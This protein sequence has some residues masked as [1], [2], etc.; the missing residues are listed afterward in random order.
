MLD[1]LNAMP[2]AVEPNSPIV[3]MVSGGSDSTALLVRSSLAPVDLK[4]GHG[5]RRLPRESLHVLH[6][7]HCLRGSESDGDEAFVRDLCNRLN[8]AFH[9]RRVDVA[10]LVREGAN[11]ED[12]ARQVRY[13]LAWELA[14]ELAWAKGLPVGAARILV[15]HTADDRAETFLMRALTGSGLTGL[16]GM[17]PRCGIVVRPLIGCTREELR[18]DLRACGIGWREDSTNAQDVATRSYVRHHVVPALSARN[19]SFVKTLGRSLDAMA[20]EEDLIARLSAELFERAVRPARAGF[21]VLDIETLAQGEP[22]LAPRCMRLALER[23]LGWQAARDAR[24]ESSHFDRLLDLVRCGAGS[25]SLPGGVQARVEQGM[26]VLRGPVVAR[27]P[28]DVVLPVPGAVKWGG[29]VLEAK[30]VALGRR[31]AEEAAH[32]L[33]LGLKER[34]LREGRDFVLVD[35]TVAGVCEPGDE[36]ALIVGGP[37]PA[38]RMRPFGLHASKL[39]SDVLPQA[40]VPAR[41]RPWVPVV[42]SFSG[43]PESEI[44]VWVGGIRLD[45]RAAWSDKTTCLIQLSLVSI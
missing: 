20:A 33:A 18:Q 9:A 6:V 26:L 19:P 43:A 23:A 15:A 10:A 39:L 44:C 16:V 37:R 13:D 38:E 3:L 34:G 41:D 24:Y 2:L 14:R 29:A 45:E 7:N 17:R 22:A 28:E 11:L 30:V 27:P 40:G 25:C 32:D 4:D 31:P 5:P 21:C 36:G 42:R 1:A 12:A 35:G 8:V